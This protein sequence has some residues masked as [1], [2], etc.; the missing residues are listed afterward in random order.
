MSC[1]H[2]DHVQTTSGHPG[3]LRLDSLN[4]ASASVCLERHSWLTLPHLM[5]T[6]LAGANVMP[7]Q[8][9]LAVP[10]TAL[11]TSMS[12]SSSEVSAL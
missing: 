3:V 2:S 8:M 7:T 6:L 12:W 11:A 5:A 10:S 4:P 1:Q 9:Q